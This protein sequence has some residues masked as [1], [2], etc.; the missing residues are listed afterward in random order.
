MLPSTLS[1][2]SQPVCKMCSRSES[3]PSPLMYLSVVHRKGHRQDILGVPQ[4]AASGLPSGQVPEAQCVIPG[5]R[6]GKL[7][8]RGDHDVLNEVRVSLQRA[9][10]EAVA[11]LLTG[12]VPHQDG[13]IP[14]GSIAHKYDIRDHMYCLQ[15]SSRMIH[16]YYK[17]IDCKLPLDTRLKLVPT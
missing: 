7:S 15:K 16:L 13:L 10:S 4:E 14:E 8:I 12:Q 9:A 3:D 1:T 5:A 11:A 2:A 6:Q 17:C